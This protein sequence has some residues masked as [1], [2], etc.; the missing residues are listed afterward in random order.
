MKKKEGGQIAHVTCSVE[1]SLVY[2][3]DQGCVSF[4]TW[5]SKGSRLEKPDRIVFDLDPPSED[6]SPVLEAA[7]Q[8][9][10]RLEARGLVPFVMSTG[11]RGLHVVVP[12]V[13]ERSFEEVRGFA[14]CVATDLA[15]EYPEAFTTEVRKKERSGRVFIDYLRNAYGQTT[16][17]PYSVRAIEGAPVAT[18]LDWS[19]LSGQ[20][21]DP[22]AYTVKNMFRRL[23]QK[24]DPWARIDDHAI[25]W[26]EI[27]EE[28]S[29]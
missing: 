17:A 8:L 29:T 11:S 15:E 18:P 19:E 6:T 2:L 3:V 21:F 28:D 23:G 26:S 9:K 13:P 14:H 22:R 1:A 24:Q 10:G 20:H 16:V 25:A 12:I 5:L 7:K 27:G 4:H